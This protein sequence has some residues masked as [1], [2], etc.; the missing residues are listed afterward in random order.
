M[1]RMNQT[2][3]TQSM[4]DLQDAIGM[5]TALKAAHAESPQAIVM[6]SVRAIEHMNVW[7]TGGALPRALAGSL[8]LVS[9]LGFE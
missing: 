9:R 5:S 2:L 4:Q 8:R 7:T 3:D 6:A 1:S